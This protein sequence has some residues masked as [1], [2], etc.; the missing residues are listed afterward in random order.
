MLELHDQFFKAAY[1]GD[2]EGVA[3][4]LAAGQDIEAVHE[5]TGLSAIHYAIGGN[6]FELTKFLVAQGATMKPDT[7][8]RWPTTLAALCEVDMELC[9]FVCDEEEKVEQAHESPPFAP[10]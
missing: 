9:D 6:H 10:A 5:M 3:A 1:K 2:I 7:D 8:G 4:A